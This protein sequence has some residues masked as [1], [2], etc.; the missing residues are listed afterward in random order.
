MFSSPQGHEHIPAVYFV[1]LLFCV[2][3]IQQGLRDERI[4]GD[5]FEAFDPAMKALEISAET[6]MADSGNL[7][8]VINV[9]GN[10]GQGGR[11]GWRS[12]RR[13]SPGPTAAPRCGGVRDL[14]LV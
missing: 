6:D 8:D 13:D 11:S 5:V 3:A 4:A 7:S 1:D 12:F 9:I 14:L 10:I 2:T